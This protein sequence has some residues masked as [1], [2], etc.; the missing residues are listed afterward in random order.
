MK[1]SSYEKRLSKHAGC[2]AFR[3][4]GGPSGSGMAGDVVT[5]TLSRLWGRQSRSPWCRGKDLSMEQQMQSK[6]VV[7]L[8]QDFLNHV[9]F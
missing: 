1:F 9:L 6:E 3:G 4:P 5:E 8:A 7:L 2:A